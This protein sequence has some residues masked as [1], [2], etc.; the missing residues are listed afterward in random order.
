MPAIMTPIPSFPTPQPF[1]SKPF[2]LSPKTFPRLSQDFPTCPL[3]NDQFPI[4]LL[5]KH[6]D[7][8]RRD[9]DIQGCSVCYR[10][11]C[12]HVAFLYRLSVPSVDVFR[13]GKQDAPIRHFIALG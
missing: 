5:A 12:F 7:A 3:W 13:K 8:R 6:T 4:S 9:P 11:R 1:S 2:H 10:I